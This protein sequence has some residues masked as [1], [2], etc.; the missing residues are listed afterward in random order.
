MFKAGDKVEFYDYNNCEKISATVVDCINKNTQILIKGKGP[1][2]Y[3]V[4]PG[5]LHHKKINNGIRN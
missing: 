2:I 3:V 5:S 4:K 1:E